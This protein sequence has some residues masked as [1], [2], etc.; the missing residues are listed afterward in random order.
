MV[1]TKN[2]Q[3][4]L[5][6]ALA[7]LLSQ[8]SVVWAVEP[9]DIL[10]PI[11]G[12]VVILPR[13]EVALSYNDNIFLSH[14]DSEKQ[15]DLLTELSPGFGL[16]YG[17]N[18]LDNNYITL[19]YSSLFRRYSESSE[20]NA[21]NHF[22]ALRI[23][24]V[25]EGKFTF[26]GSD[27]IRL[28]NTLLQGRERSFIS[29]LSDNGEGDRAMLVERLSSIDSYRF[30][31]TISPKTSVYFATGLN[32]TDYEEEPHYYYKNVFGELIPN[33]LFDVSEWNNTAGFGWQAF[34]KVRFYGSFFYGITAVETNLDSMGLRPDSDFFGGHI[35][36]NGRFADKLTSSLLLGYQTRDFDRLSN[37]MG[38]DSHS[39]PIFE[40]EID[41]NY[42]Q[43]GVASVSYKRGGIV[44]PE[45]PNLAIKSDFLELA[46]DQ[47][48]G[49]TGKLSS[50]LNTIFQLDSFE[51]SGNPEYKYTTL[52]LK[53]SYSF[54]EWMKSSLSYGLNHFNSN[55]GNIDYTSNQFMLSFAV[56]Y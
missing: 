27:N 55:K 47:K 3:Y 31:Y 10:A 30:E 28:D 25:K 17:R 20:L 53:L 54:N 22:L 29:S 23:N 19:D 51:T 8:M 41:Y 36:L 13:A 56:G 33:A 6:I 37:G 4:S 15:D 24:Y 48:L 35:S 40:A 34:P 32:M 2:D 1:C 7:A 16:R 11:V 26:S 43:K 38:G 12:P 44:S 14:Y 50:S 49:V 46:I 18:I 5:L 21:D 9:E 42:S 52:N 39:L 45:D